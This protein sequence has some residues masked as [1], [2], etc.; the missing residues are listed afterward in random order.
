MPDF[1]EALCARE[2]VDPEQFFGPHVCSDECDGVRGCYIAKAETGRF[3]RI[4]DAKA[5]CRRCPVIAECLEWALDTAQPFGIW[6]GTTERDRR[7]IIKE[8]QS[9]GE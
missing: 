9:R 1:P 2:G 3:R 7:V 4:S 8:R 6:G 5:M